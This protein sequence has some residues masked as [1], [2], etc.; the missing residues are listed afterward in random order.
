MSLGL[1]QLMLVVG[2]V[3]LRDIGQYLPE[4]C[5]VIRKWGGLENGIANLYKGE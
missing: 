4:K 1:N 3:V 5:S 2:L